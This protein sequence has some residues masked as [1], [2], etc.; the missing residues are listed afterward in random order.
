MPYASLSLRNEVADRHVEYV[1]GEIKI[2]DGE[3]GRCISIA[4]MI[5]TLNLDKAR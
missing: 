3:S 1:S 5:R 2:P 4:R